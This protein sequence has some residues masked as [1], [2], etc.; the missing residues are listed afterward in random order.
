MTRLRQT[1]GRGYTKG[2][3]T[4]VSVRL[5]AD[6]IERLD[7]LGVVLAPFGTE[8]TRSIAMR[9]TVL[10]GLEVLEREHAKNVKG[11]AK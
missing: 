11:S 8:P 1:T 4:H 6:T 3:T 9:A 7:A 5:D 10:K 2:G